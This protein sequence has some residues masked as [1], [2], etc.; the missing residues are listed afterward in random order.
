MKRRFIDNLTSKQ[1][2]EFPVCTGAVDYAP[3]A[4]AAV[5]HISYLG[6]E[7]H[8]EGQ[9]LHHARGKSGDHADCDVRHQSTRFDIDP[10]YADDI[11]APVFHL[12]E[13]AWR[14]LLQLQEE[15]ERVYNLSPAPAAR[16]PHESQDMRER[17]LIR[18]AFGGDVPPPPSDV[19]PVDEPGFTLTVTGVMPDPSTEPDDVRMGGS[20]PPPRA[21]E[22]CTCCDCTP[23][24]CCCGKSPPT[25]GDGGIK[26][27]IDCDGGMKR[28]GVGRGAE[29]IPPEGFDS[30]D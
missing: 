28:L 4:L 10:A 12:A 17:A 30:G 3:D 18:L 22:V 19:E 25:P 2:K 7:K 13:H 27:G 9:P 15:M 6:N 8:N 24:T 1:R 16:W 29:I 5:S 26:P 11:L 23:G 14:A 20:P 21:F